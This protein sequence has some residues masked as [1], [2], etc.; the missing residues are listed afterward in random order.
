MSAKLEAK[1][2]PLL[3]A[4]MN[5][6]I[7]GVPRME[8]TQRRGTKSAR[9][10]IPL[11]NPQNGRVEELVLTASAFRDLPN[12]WISAIAAGEVLFRADAGWLKSG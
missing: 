10:I 4:K 3:A 6:M 7:C 2:D 11:T 5:G 8:L 9:L 1:F 12:S